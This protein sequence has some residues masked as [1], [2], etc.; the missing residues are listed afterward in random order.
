MLCDLTYT[1]ITKSVDL[2]MHSFKIPKI[3]QICH[4]SVA[5]TTK[6]FELKFCKFVGYNIGCS[7]NFFQIF[8]KLVY[9]VFKKFK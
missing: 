4:I 6:N 7:Q 9:I 3:Y 8:L 5:H 1:K 2:S